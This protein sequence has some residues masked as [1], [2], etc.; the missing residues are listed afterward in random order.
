MATS[1]E[2]PVE[3]LEA[4]VLI[5]EHRSMAPRVLHHLAFRTDDVDRL[6]TF[7]R[8]VV[9]LPLRDAREIFETEYL[10]AQLDRFGGNV[11]KTASFIGMERSA[12]HRKLK[13]LGV[14]NK[15]LQEMPEE[16]LVG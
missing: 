2:V 1:T 12:F 15:E 14:K 10:A 5:G 4:E 7:Y 6:T 9:G 8:E 3:A 13:S 16:E 11:S